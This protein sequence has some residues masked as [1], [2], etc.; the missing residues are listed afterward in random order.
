MRIYD[1]IDKKRH[2]VSLTD[3]EIEF[4]ISTY[5]SG[6]T[7]DYQIS[8]LL[9]AICINS[10][11][12]RETNI[13]TRAMINSG[14]VLDLSPLGNLTVD[15][16]STGGIGDKT[17]LIVAPIVSSIGCTVAKMSGRGLGFTGGTVDKLESI[18]GFKTELSTEEF[19]MQA[20]NKGIVVVGQSASLTPADKKLYA[21][22]DVTA[23][24]DSIPLIASSIM[25]K[26]IASGSKS[27][28]L[29]VKYGSGAF[30]KTP[31]DAEKL[32]SAMIKIGKSFNRNVTAVITDMN[33]PLGLC[34]GNSLE[35]WEAIKTLS[36]MG[37]EN[38]TCL[39]KTVSAC[40]VSSAMDVDYD[41]A[42]AMVE[43]AVSSGKA[44][45][46]FYEWIEAQGGDL[47]AVKNP[48]LLLSAKF[49]RE[50]CAK[51]NGYIYSL[52]AEKIGTSSM[53]LGAGRIKK[54]DKIDHLAGIVLEKSLGDYVA[55]GDVLATLYTSNEDLFEN[56]FCVF[57]GA[58]SYSQEPPQ[59]NEL[60]YKIIK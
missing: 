50:I 42:L 23:T 35:V 38:L 41:S 47:A 17:T 48:S 5:M 51:E 19:L 21:L 22:R 29:D 25:S 16:H 32:A 43:K 6:E 45:E 24:I 57:E 26:K 1:I 39:T 20:K 36:G 46:K 52:D 28:V 40:M 12:E 55:K 60:I 4:T 7:K 13:L 58:I 54:E 2:G 49:K 3:E 33:K 31:E 56:A 37:E 53:I 10:M 30:M 18:N 44:L 11:D 8:A 15:K 9:M 14:E 34:V 59:Q 27:I